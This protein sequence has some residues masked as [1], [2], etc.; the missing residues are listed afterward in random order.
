MACLFALDCPAD[1]RSF[2]P[3]RAHSCYL[4]IGGKF[5]DLEEDSGHCAPESKPPNG[6]GACRASD[7][8]YHVLQ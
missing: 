2:G 8:S 3:R 6:P 5:D 4:F 7:K 1:G